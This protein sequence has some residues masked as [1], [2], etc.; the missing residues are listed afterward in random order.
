MF[1]AYKPRHLIF[2]IAFNLRISMIDNVHGSHSCSFLFSRLS[3]YQEAALGETP[4]GIRVCLFKY[5]GEEECV[6]SFLS[7][8]EKFKAAPESREIYGEGG[9]FVVKHGDDQL[10]FAEPYKGYLIAL[11]SAVSPFDGKSIAERIR[12]GIDAVSGKDLLRKSR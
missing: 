2:T 11:M 4:D 12:N 7:M 8:K 5:P 10:L 3:D 6:E 1:I 9:S